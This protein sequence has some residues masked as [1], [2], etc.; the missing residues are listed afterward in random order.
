M[1]I[2]TLTHLYNL[3]QAE[4]IPALEKDLRSYKDHNEQ[5]RAT[6]EMKAESERTLNLTQESL[7]MSIK[8][9]E[10]DNKNMVLKCEE[11]QFRVG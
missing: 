4:D 6:I 9:K 8:E 7:Y 11:L 10:A 5:L 1:I 2:H 3:F